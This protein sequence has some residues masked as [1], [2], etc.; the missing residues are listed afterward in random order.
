RDDL[1]RVVHIEARRVLRRLRR[2][3]GAAG[4]Q[5][6]PV[7]L[8]A[9]RGARH[10]TRRAEG[11][12]RAMNAPSEFLDYGSEAIIMAGLNGRNWRL[13][14]YVARAGYE[15]FKKILAEKTPPAA[16]IAEGKKSALRGRRC[17]WFPT[18]LKWTFMPQHA[19]GDKYLACSSYG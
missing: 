15:A 14:D 4:Q 13:A 8:D 3:A 16:I 17:A 6:A 9:A 18:A 10:A 1:R 5:Q 12:S 2:C 11:G 19:A 7:Q